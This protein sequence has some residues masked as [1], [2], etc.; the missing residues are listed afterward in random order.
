MMARLGAVALA[1][2]C[3]TGGC[4]ARPGG[5]APSSTTTLTVQQGALARTVV[6]HVPPAHASDALP[7]LLNLH[8]SGGT[9]AGQEQYTGM[10]ALA[11]AHGFI[12]AYPQGAIVA[13]A[14]YSWNVPG[15]PLSDGSAVPPGS[16]DDRDFAALAVA[17]V[18]KLHRIDDKRVFAT[19]FSGGARM[20]S[21]LGCD[22]PSLFAA[23]GPVS[24]LRSPTPCGQPAVAVVTLHGDADATNPYSGSDKPYWTYGVPQAAANWAAHDGC[25]PT[26]TVSQLAPDL[27]LTRYDGCARHADVELYTIAGGGHAWP[28]A[29]DA[30][31][32]SAIDAG[33]ISWQFFAAHPQP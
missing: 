11:D 33:E 22:R 21:Q 13:G 16:A 17:A 28:R 31:G 19:G 8:A 29:S 6:V 18:S 23:I 4:H 32:G 25:A 2:A 20:A 9:A 14:G 1:A 10:D 5:L 3:L 26:P 27:T 24:G 15:V 7:L 12:V 30:D